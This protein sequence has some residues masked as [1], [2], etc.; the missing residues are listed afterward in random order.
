[1]K[2]LAGTFMALLMI[3]PIGRAQELNATSGREHIIARFATPLSSPDVISLVHRLNLAPRELYFE[4][5]TSSET[6]LAGGYILHRGE[7]IETA[8]QNLN[9]KHSAFLRDAILS[10][11]GAMTAASDPVIVSQLHGLQDQLRA[12]AGVEG[13]TISSLRVEN[14][15]ALVEMLHSHM[16]RSIEAAGDVA[17]TSLTTSAVNSNEKSYP[18]A[19]TIGTSEVTQDFTF[20]TFIFTQPH[21]FADTWS[22]EHETQIY[23]TNFAQDAG[24]WSSNMPNA[25]HDAYFVDKIGIEGLSSDVFNPTVGTAT[26]SLLKTLTMYFTYVGLSHDSPAG[27]RVIIRGQRGHRSPSYCYSLWCVQPDQTTFPSSFATYLAG[28]DVTVNW[29][30]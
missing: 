4:V 28:P 15:P 13:F 17:D 14:S 12:A 24:Y 11:A 10:L 18:W 20:Q 29:T 30:Y 21:P 1:M 9:E 27:A 2:N 23:N 6:P 3:V 25:Y 22:Y 19:P 8:F 7:S 16:L 5:P 26:A